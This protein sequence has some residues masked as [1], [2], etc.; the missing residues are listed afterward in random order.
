MTLEEEIVMSSWTP[1][2][3]DIVETLTRRVRMLSYSQV[4]R[5]VGSPRTADKKVRRM[6][7]RLTQAQLLMRTIANVMICPAASPLFVWQPGREGPCAGQLSETARRRWPSAA[8]PTEVYWASKLAANL[9][10]SSAGCH[11]NI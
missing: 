2:E 3:L 7:R 10:G 5:V 8:V 6:L 11:V 9:F 4:R 1:Q